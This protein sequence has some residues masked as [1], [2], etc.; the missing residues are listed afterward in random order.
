MFSRKN[1]LLE[2]YRKSIDVFEEYCFVND[3]VWGF[4]TGGKSKTNF[5]RK[6]N[7][8]FWY[9]KKEYI[10]NYDEIALER[11]TSTMHEGVYY[12]EENRP[13]QRNIKVG[14]EYRYYLDKGV[15]PPD[16]WT[17]IQAINPSAHERLDYPTQKPEK[18][19][20]RILKTSSNKKDIVLDA[21]A[22]SGETPL[23]AW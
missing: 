5:P 4:D 18:L 14:K 21:F 13:Y 9:K 11:D 8:I 19:L 16:Y 6:H 22:G 2:I 7:N 10:F 20:E 23:T 1:S 17:D 12:D 3:I 15:L